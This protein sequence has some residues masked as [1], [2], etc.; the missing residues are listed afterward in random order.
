MSTKSSLFLTKDNEHCYEELSEPRYVEGEYIGSSIILELNRKN[1]KILA[2]DDD[3]LILEI[4]P[5][6]E[7]YDLI[8]IM[9]R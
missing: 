2:F 1:I 5:G 9:K 6:S 4:E 7:L 3:D 8:K